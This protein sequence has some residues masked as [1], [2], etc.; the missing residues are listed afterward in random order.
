MVVSVKAPEDPV[1]VK[2]V[3]PVAAVAL[4]VRVRVL[5][6]VAGSG[7]NC[8]VTPVGKPETEKLTPP[9]KPFTGLMVI[10]LVPAAPCATLR[11]AGVAKSPKLGAEGQL[12]TRL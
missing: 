2:E 6:V 5:A 11:V 4:T 8:A 7:V 3:A 12:F 10:V 1:T 9:L